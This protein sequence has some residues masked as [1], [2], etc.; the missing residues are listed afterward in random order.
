[1]FEPDWNDDEKELFRFLAKHFDEKGKI[2][3][4]SEFPRFD[5]VKKSGV[6]RETTRLY[7]YGL[8]S[9]YGPTG[10]IIPHALLEVAYELDH[11]P[12]KDYRKVIPD[13]FFS[14]PWSI[15]VL[16]IAVVLPALYQW[17]EIIVKV[18]RGMG[19]LE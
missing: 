5:K 19:I 2:V 4:F 11:P 14:K 7:R 8:L 16:V 13:W 3:E 18:L 6:V 9:D 12:R 1:M 10:Y 17:W 15:P